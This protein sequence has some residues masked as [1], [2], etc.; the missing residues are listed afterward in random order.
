MIAVVPAMRRSNPSPTIIEARNRLAKSPENQIRRRHHGLRDSVPRVPVELVKPDVTRP[1]RLL[2]GCSIPNHRQTCRSTW[3]SQSLSSAS[4]NVTGNSTYWLL[5][6]E[7]P[8]S[9][10]SRWWAPSTHRASRAEHVHPRANGV[11]FCKQNVR[12]ELVAKMRTSAICGVLEVSRIHPR[13]L[14]SNG[15]AHPKALGLGVGPE[16][17]APCNG[18]RRTFI[19]DMQFPRS[20]FI[21]VIVRSIC[22]NLIFRSCA[23]PVPPAICSTPSVC[24]GL[25]C[26]LRAAG[27]SPAD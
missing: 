6:C 19:Q 2:D 5:K 22:S 27:P 8:G 14:G 15:Q 1:P 24:F 18:Q 26:V 3:C 20:L 13:T 12:H 10:W 25:R 7:T 11:G 21:F 4:L 23:L 16:G 17:H 9:R